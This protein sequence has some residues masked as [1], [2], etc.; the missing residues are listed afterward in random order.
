[1]SY[2]LIP[3]DATTTVEKIAYVGMNLVLPLLY[4]YMLL[5]AFQVFKN[6]YQKAV[7]AAGWAWY[8]PGI[9]FTAL[10]VYSV[11]VFA[12][13]EDVVI[14]K[15]KIKPSLGYIAILFVLSLLAY[16]GF[17]SPYKF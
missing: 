8:I 12:N 13:D 1:M 5:S 14:G 4:V 17:T 3:K 16:A 10:L 7:A 15:V 2:K 6:F 9:L 11:I